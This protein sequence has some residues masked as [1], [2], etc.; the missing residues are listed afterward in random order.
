MYLLYS[1]Q[2]DFL[3][4]K[5]Y[6]D[7]VTIQYTGDLVCLLSKALENFLLSMERLAEEIKKLRVDGWLGFGMVMFRLI[8]NNDGCLDSNKI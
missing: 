6:G 1:F 4:F 3:K 5:I 2:F 7:H 8:P